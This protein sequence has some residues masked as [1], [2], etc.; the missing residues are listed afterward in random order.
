MVTTGSQKIT[1]G[2]PG[3][4]LGIL[5]VKNRCNSAEKDFIK[6]NN[7]PVYICVS[8]TG[9]AETPVTDCV[10]AADKAQC[11]KTKISV[12]DSPTCC[13]PVTYNI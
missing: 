12:F 2:G 4:P 7:V 8:L 9:E 1:V 11:F 3:T 10:S 6:T 13:V 5:R